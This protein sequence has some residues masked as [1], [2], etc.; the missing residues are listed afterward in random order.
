MI[1]TVNLNPSTDIVAPVSSIEKGAVLRSKKILSYPG[2]KASNT[3]RV[4]SLLGIRPVLAGF[5]GDSDLPGT[6]HFFLNHKINPDLI[7]VKGENRICIILNE[8]SPVSETVINSG[9][10]FRAAPAQKTELIKKI[11]QHSKI[12][13]YTLISGSLPDCLPVTFYKTLINTIKRDTHVFL[14]ASGKAL[15]HGIK[16]MPDTV[17]V[18]IDELSS[19]FNTTLDSEHKI[20]TTVSDLCRRYKIKTF[21]LTLGE[22]GF[23]HYSKERFVF[24]PP[25]GLKNIISSVGS[26][27]AF[28]GGYLYAASM[29]FKGLTPAKYGAACAYA[30]L[31]N[32]GACFITK[33]GILKYLPLVSFRDY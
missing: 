30:N 4:L 12:S 32:L 16:A 6:I 26:G 3:A 8:F 21:I 10:V 11:K 25:P 1:L 9:S 22:K 28:S 20:K 2:G 15:F 33:S 5:C 31:F 24:F 14:D 13:P 19:A 18:N 17:K 29:G 7:P 27:D 23:I